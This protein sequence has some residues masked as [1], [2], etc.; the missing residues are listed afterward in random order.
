MGRQRLP[1]GHSLVVAVHQHW[2]VPGAGSAGIGGRRLPS[3]IG[4]EPSSS[5]VAPTPFASRARIIDG[6]SREGFPTC[7]RS[8]IDRVTAARLSQMATSVTGHEICVLSWAICVQR[9]IGAPPTAFRPARTQPNRSW[10][11]RESNPRPPVPQ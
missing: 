6:G 8:P 2:C 4:V 3:H 1:T 7:S 10:R 5:R 11:W 9:G